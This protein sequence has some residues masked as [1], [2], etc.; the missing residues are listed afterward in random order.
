MSAL[1]VAGAVRFVVGPP[2]LALR[3]PWP[4]RWVRVV[5]GSGLCLLGGVLVPVPP[6][7]GWCGF[8]SCPRVLAPLAPRYV[9]CCLVCSTLQVIRCSWTGLLD[10]TCRRRKAH[11]A[12]G[13]CRWSRVLG[14]VP[15][16]G[17]VFGGNVLVFA[18]RWGLHGRGKWLSTSYVPSGSVGPSGW[19]SQSP[20]IGYSLAGKAKEC[21]HHLVGD[22]ELSS[23]TNGGRGDRWRWADHGTNCVEGG[24]VSGELWF[25]P[26][27]S[28]H[29]SRFFMFSG[30]PW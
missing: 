13:R 21:A 10:R 30:C 23:G 15:P 11:G 4:F 16:P 14:P 20:V 25:C 1:F 9:L 22:S 18:L 3:C 29:H 5:G 19:G 2:H 12:R 17:Q 8:L 26:P 24:G 28:E 27:R 7:V 6:P